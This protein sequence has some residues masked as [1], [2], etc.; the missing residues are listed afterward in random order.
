VESE[1]KTHLVIGALAVAVVALGIY[2]VYA[3]NPSAPPSVSAGTQ[4]ASQDS[5]APAVSVGEAGSLHIETEKQVLANGGAHEARAVSEKELDY[6]WSITGG[7][8][9]GPGV[10][11]M[12]TWKPGA[13]PE[14][15]L[16]CTGTAPDGAVIT[17]TTRIRLQA[18]SAIT[19]FEAVPPL[20]TEGTSARLFWAASNATK[21]VLE[22]GGQDLGKA[23]A[24]S[25]EVKPTETTT[26]TLKATDA[27]G[28]TTTQELKLKVVPAPE[29]TSFRADPVAG[30]RDSFTVL[31][32]F[33][34]GKGELKRDGKVI[35]NSETSPLQVPLTDLGQ[36][37]YLLLTITNEAGAYTSNSLSFSARK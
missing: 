37:G 16:V 1:Q 36:G 29:I 3:G 12:V 32:A 14:A 10:G 15:L 21:V 4:T 8:L 9:E 24:S 26:Y 34:G 7:T 17:A 22:P 6:R 18:P 31:A 25:V 27:L 2:A 20:I 30:S 13:G 19:R 33:K 28:T 35:A 23:V 11:A 5:V